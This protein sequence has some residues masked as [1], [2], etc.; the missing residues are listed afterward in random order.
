M[1]G[2]AGADTTT[3]PVQFVVLNVILH[4]ELQRRAQAE[5]DSVIGSPDSQTFRLPTLE[6]VPSL[7]YITALLKESLRWV[8]VQPISLP[9]ASIE[10][11]EFRGWRIPKGSVI[12]PNAWTM[13]HDEKTY[14]DPFEFRPERFLSS[15]G[16]E[17]EPNPSNL[18]VFGFGRRCV[19]S[20]LLYDDDNGDN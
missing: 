20:V 1:V 17:P 4:P 13:L 8:P 2:L 10:E 11:S 7:P 14:K 16:H 19:I 3:T 5:L 15:E 9:H 18:G 12:L 6:D